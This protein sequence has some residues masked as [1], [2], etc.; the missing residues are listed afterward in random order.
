MKGSYILFIKLNNNQNIKYSTKE[1][2]VFK[3]GYYIYVGS[4]LN[5]LESRIERHLR[6]VNKKK[7]WHIDY[8]LIYGQILNIFYK[9][10]SYREECDI[11]NLLKEKFL[12]IPKFGS[13]DCK[14]TT[15]LFYGSKNELL[16]FINE[17]KMKEYFIQKT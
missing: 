1:K 11:A 9:E 12:P 7:F 8:L 4:A 14:C 17:N 6:N 13:S 16:K 10:N 5:S 15:H 2:F 3:K